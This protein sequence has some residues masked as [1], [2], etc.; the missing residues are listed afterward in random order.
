[1]G[2]GDIA[3]QI[4]LSD[5]IKIQQDLKRREPTQKEVIGAGGTRGVGECAIDQ[6]ASETSPNR[7]SEKHT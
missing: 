2:E 3:P 4:N 6:L 1:M 7:P 5:R